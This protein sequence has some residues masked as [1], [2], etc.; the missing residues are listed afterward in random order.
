MPLG[1]PAGPSF[2]HCSVVAPAHS[3]QLTIT[4][5]SFIALSHSTGV[6]AVLAMLPVVPF[7]IRWFTGTTL[8]V[9]GK[10]YNDSVTETRYSRLPAGAKAQVRPSV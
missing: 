3:S 4:P 10:A 5:P 6:C 9:G 7:A 8:E 1:N 2:N